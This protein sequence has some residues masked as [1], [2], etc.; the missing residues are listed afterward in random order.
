[1][2]QILLEVRLA[3]G[4]R[5]KTKTQHTCLGGADFAPDHPRVNP[6]HHA[7]IHKDH[8]QRQDVLGRSEHTSIEKNRA[9]DTRL[10]VV[11]RALLPLFH[12]RHQHDSGGFDDV[13]ILHGAGTVQR[14]RIRGDR[15]RGVLHGTEAQNKQARPVASERRRDTAQAEIHIELLGRC[16]ISQRY[17]QI[18]WDHQR[19]A[20]R[21]YTLAGAD[22]Q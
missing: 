15:I 17:G 19:F 9:C 6:L 21:C 3:Q 22:R 8:G 20:R 16:N 7:A 12:I 13:S 14:R 2:I 18:R 1:M 4:P 10:A 11:C 5:R